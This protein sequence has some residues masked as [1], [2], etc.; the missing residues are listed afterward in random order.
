MSRVLVT[1]GCGFVG[2]HLVD[3]LLEQDHEVVVYDNLSTGRLEFLPKHER[4]RFIEGYLL[5]FPAL[6]R[7]F[8][9]CSSVF[10]IAGHADV[11][12]GKDDGGFR[13]LEENAKGTL[14][15]LNA[16]RQTGVKHISF[17]S[18]AVVYGEPNVFPTPEYHCGDQTSTYGAA[19]Q[20]A[21]ALIHAH[22]NYYGITGA[23][24]R[25]VSLLGERYQH[26]VVFDFVKQLLKHPEHLEILGNGSQSKSYLYVKDC[27]QGVICAKRS[28]GAVE[29]YNL[30][31]GYGLQVSAV[32]GIIA[33]AMGLK[34]SLHYGS[35]KRGWPGD[36][37]VVNLDTSKI[38]EQ[39][40]RPSISIMEAIQRTVKWLL[41]NKSMMYGISG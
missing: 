4:V 10:H 32:A 35:D 11:R 22:C 41:D 38:R 5:D 13:D 19:K 31:Q 7:A 15:V 33:D 8:E 36:S 3:A 1:G 28:T 27:V 30:G 40:W 29:T 21:E 37:P 24:F 23:I 12:G 16:M 18:S 2:S 20:Y 6:C 34:P 14:N 17:S 39:G 25:F 26:G 9:G